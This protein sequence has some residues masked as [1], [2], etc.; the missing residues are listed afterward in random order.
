[1]AKLLKTKALGYLRTSSATNTGPEADSEPRQRAAIAAYAAFSGLEVIGWYY[2]VQSGADALESRPGFAALLDHIEGNGVRTVIV[3]DASRFARDLMTQELGVLML[4]KRGVTLITATSENLTQTDDAM[5]KAMR[6]MAGV[7][8]ELE[9]ARLVAKLKHARDE[10]RKKNG[11]CEGS[12]PVAERYRDATL[13]ALVLHNVE[14]PPTYREIAATLTAEGFMSVTK[15]K[16][17]ITAHGAKKR[18]D[19]YKEVPFTPMAVWRMV[20]SRLPQ[21]AA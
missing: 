9:K 18:V 17:I 12:K 8:S 21:T 15:T 19:S 2:D 16:N 6:Q 7:F 1:M 10:K 4:Q 14:Q 13:R 5:K 3:E 20:R 11:K